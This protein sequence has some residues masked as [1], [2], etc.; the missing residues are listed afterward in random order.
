MISISIIVPVYN[1]E[2]F[3]PKCIESILY[4]SYSSFEL[5]LVDDGSTDN[6]GFIC[7]EYKEKDNRITVI[8][9]KNG[10]VSSARNLGLERSVGDWVCF[11]DSDDWVEH[12]FLNNFI[13]RCFTFK[14]DVY[15][16]SFYT[17]TKNGAKEVLLPNMTIQGTHNLV[18]WLEYSELVHNGWIWHRMFNNRIIKAYS[19]RFPENLSISEDGVFWL[20]YLKYVKSAYLFSDLGYHYNFFNENSLTDKDKKKFNIQTEELIIKSIHDG[21]IN[22]NVTKEE[23]D[24]HENFIKEYLWKFI[25]HRILRH[26]YKCKIDKKDCVEFAKKMIL[27]YDLYKVNN[28][29]LSYKIISFCFKNSEC[30]FFDDLLNL[31]F[32]LR[33]ENRFINLFFNKVDIMTK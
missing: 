28:L 18:K 8:H 27:S 7:D 12:N 23:F 19:I 24:S 10:G 20:Q 25:I 3:L 16:Q 13:S 4:Q 21:L 33:Y 31:F 14:A 11:I 30:I 26:A 32:K 15:L 9:K 17:H 29:N 5:I 6:S 1:S 2:K 22:L